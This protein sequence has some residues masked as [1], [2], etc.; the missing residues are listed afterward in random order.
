MADTDRRSFLKLGGA[1]TIVVSSGQVWRSFAQS[2]AEID[3]KPE[4]EPWRTWRDDMS[5]GPL[6]LVRA[7][8]LSSN[9]YNSQPWIFAVHDDRIEVFA[10]VKRNLG[11]FDPYLREMFF[12]LGCALENL[13]LAG[14]ANGYRCST[15]LVRGNLSAVPQDTRP[16]LA[17]RIKLDH[18][19]HQASELHEAIPQRHT[20]REPFDVD[21]R[22]PDPF[23]AELQALDRTESQVKIFLFTEPAEL[24]RIVELISTST[25]K[26]LSDPEVRKGVQPWLRHTAEEMRNFRDGFLLDAQASRYGTL[27]AYAHLMHTGRVF[28]LI[29]V[30]DRYD[31]VQTIRAGR[32]WQRSHLLASARGVAAR[33]ANGAIELIDHER[34]RAQRPLTTEALARFTRD[35]TWQPTFMFYMGYATVPAEAS[36]RRPLDDVLLRSDGH[37]PPS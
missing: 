14:E 35:D 7:A 17:A 26:F 3:D 18:A 24:Q 21:R 29:A 34:Q 8:I 5:H 31:R 16:V 37:R 13:E 4:L 6:L 32:I 11:D 12:S 33:P 19:K 25:G 2:T 1:I 15:Q 20:N 9:A 23:L 10:D 30:R 27:E 36:P 28:G 22:L